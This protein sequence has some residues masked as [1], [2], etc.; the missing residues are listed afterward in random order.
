M[1]EGALLANRQEVGTRKTSTRNNA[2]NCNKGSGKNKNYP[3]CHHCEKTGY[4]PL[5]C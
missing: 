4:P 1:V 3:P 5:R 2:D